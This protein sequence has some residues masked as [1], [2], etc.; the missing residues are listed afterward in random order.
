M[1]VEYNILLLPIGETEALTRKWPAQGH[2]FSSERGKLRRP[3]G[4]GQSTVTTLRLRG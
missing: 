4:K 3:P 1:T 2:L